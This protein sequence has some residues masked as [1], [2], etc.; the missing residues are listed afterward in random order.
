MAR[1]AAPGAMQISSLVPAWGLRD[2]VQPDGG[3]AMTPAIVNNP[4]STRICANMSLVRCS[5]GR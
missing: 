5:R 4:A 2:A 3:G 1:G